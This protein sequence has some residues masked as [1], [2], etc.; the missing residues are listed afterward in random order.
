MEELTSGDLYRFV[1]GDR[2]RAKVLW[3]DGTG[4]HLRQASRAGGRSAI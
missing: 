4:L 1:S 3:W 2:L